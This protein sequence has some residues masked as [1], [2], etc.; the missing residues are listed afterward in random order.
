MANLCTLLHH[1]LPNIAPVLIVIYSINIGAVVISEAS[2]SFLGVRAA[3]HG[4]ELG[5][6]C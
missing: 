1:L 2:L 4:A 3:D 6:H 5:R